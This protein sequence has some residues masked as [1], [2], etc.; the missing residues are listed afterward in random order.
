M[1]VSRLVILILCN[2]LLPFGFQGTDGKLAPQSLEEM[3][4]ILNGSIPIEDCN[5]D[6]PGI[7]RM[8]FCQKT[9][10]PNTTHETVLVY[11]KDI[12]RTYAIVAMVASCVGLLG[13]ALVFV[14]AVGNWKDLHR[15]KKMIA[16]LAVCDFL[17]ALVLLINTVPMTWTNKYLYG[18]YACKI[19]NPAFTLGSFIA[20]GI[21]FIIALERFFGIVFPFGV[22]GREVPPKLWPVCL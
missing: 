13:N 6:H 14:V 21:I 22:N 3:C 19:L 7:G 5:C 2:G 17:F 15:V 16:A 9:I 18:R 12:S 1:Q 4:K 20:M 11:N 8:H 10:A